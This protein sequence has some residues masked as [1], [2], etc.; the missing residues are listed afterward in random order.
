MHSRGERPRMTDGHA[1]KPRK[2]IRFEQF[3]SVTG[4]DKCK[5]DY[6]EK[7]RTKIICT[8]ITAVLAAVTGGSVLNLQCTE[9]HSKKLLMEMSFKFWVKLV[10]ISLLMDLTDSTEELISEYKKVIDENSQYQTNQTTLQGR[11]QSLQ[12]ENDDLKSQI[13][14]LKGTLLNTYSS[15][16]INSVIEQ[17]GLKR[18][19]FQAP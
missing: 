17:G 19:H 12:S 1:Q 18:E 13:Q 10:V 14:I 2:D 4:K 5:N 8:V 6:E 9:C 7:N 11:V 3:T 15:D 16:E